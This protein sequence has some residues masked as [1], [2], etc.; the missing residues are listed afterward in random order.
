MP[1][2]YAKGVCAVQSSDRLHLSRH[3][4]W[5][6]TPIDGY[7]KGWITGELHP[8]YYE[9]VDNNFNRLEAI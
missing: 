9:E 3:E 8:Q 2:R 1:L 6:Y 5:H 4:V 7:L